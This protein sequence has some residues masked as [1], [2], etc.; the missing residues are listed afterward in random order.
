MAVSARSKRAAAASV[1]AGAVLWGTVGVA[2]ELAAPSANPATVAGVRSLGGGALLVLAVLVAGDGERMRAVLRTA[3]ALA[4]AA[5]A[6]IT[7]FQLGYLTGIRLGGV[8]VGTLLAIGTAPVFAGVIGAVRGEPPG[9]RWVWATVLTVLGAAALLLGPQTTPGAPTGSARLLGAVLS[10]GAGAA[11]ATATVVSRELLVRGLHGPS[12][13]AVMF[14]GAGIALLPVTVLGGLGWVTSLPGALGAIWLA[15]ATTLVGYRLFARGL[16]GVDA[17]GA[18]TL[19]LAEP[20]TAAVLG[21]AVLG[22]RLSP[23]GVLGA[24]L[25]AAGLV[26]LAR[27]PTSAQRAH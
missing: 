10:V 22:E 20:L 1:V 24:A 12:V 23:P 19:T 13:M 18:T 7:V 6:A 3:P 14:A 9:R 27:D 5:A 21:V 4:L 16:R 17:A 2:Q 15:V 26:L 25:L 8:A 11:Y